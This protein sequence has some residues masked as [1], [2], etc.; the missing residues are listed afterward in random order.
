MSDENVDDITVVRQPERGRYALLDGEK[1]I[2]T[3]AYLDRDGRRIFYHTVVDEAYGG[4]GLASRLVR[5][6]LEDSFAEGVAVVPVCP[7][8]RAWLRRH[9]EIAGRTTPADAD[10]LA[11]LHQLG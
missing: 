3:A 9:P 1:R 2:G 10:D 5:E 6:A 7:Y 11:A 8:V 4:R